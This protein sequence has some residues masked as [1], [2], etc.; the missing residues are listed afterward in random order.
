MIN[1]TATP[2][3]DPFDATQDELDALTR[4]SLAPVP[5]RKALVEHLPTRLYERGFIT[6]NHDG[7]LMLTDKGLALIRH[8]QP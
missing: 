7:Q 5:I 6:T 8:Q 4:L 2:I 1:T 3:A